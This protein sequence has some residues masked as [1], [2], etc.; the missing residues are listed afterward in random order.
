VSDPARQVLAAVGDEDFAEH[1]GYPFGGKMTNGTEQRL[2][3]ADFG[4]FARWYSARFMRA[5]GRLPSS[6]TTVTKQRRLAAASSVLGADTVE[7]FGTLLSERG[8]VEVLLDKLL[9]ERSSGTVRGTVYDLI[10]FGEWLVARGMSSIALT[11]A[12]LPPENPQGAIQVYTAEEVELMLSAARGNSLRWWAFLTFLADTGRRV[13]EVLGL[14]WAWFRLDGERPYVELPHT[15]NG[16][17]QLVPL[18]RRLREEVFT[19]EH[20]DQ[21]K[22]AENRNMAKAARSVEVHPF[23]WQYGVVHQRF[24]RFCRRV[25]VEPRGFHCFRHTKATQLFAAGAPIQAVSRLLGHSAVATTDRIY[26]QTT[27]LTY[28]EWTE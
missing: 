11:R 26:N 5:K 24:E 23:P 6:A 9:A 14:Q 8:N 19:P 25:D 7:M 4:D 12:D 27:A 18:S 2:W 16:R 13:G 20:I 28:A 22:L 21:L 10:D 3:A 15:K 17:P 1:S